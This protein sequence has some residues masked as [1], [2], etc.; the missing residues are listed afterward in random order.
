MMTDLTYLVTKT[1]NMNSHIALFP[2]QK[3]LRCLHLLSFSLVALVPLEST[4]FS[5]Q[6]AP[7]EMVFN[8]QVDTSAL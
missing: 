4:L 7:F 3:D 8:R 1:L 2:R 6:Q 5:P